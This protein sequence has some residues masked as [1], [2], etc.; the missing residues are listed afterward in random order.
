MAAGR[1]QDSPPFQQLRRAEIRK[2]QG[3]STIVAGIGSFVRKFD[4]FRAFTGL[5]QLSPTKN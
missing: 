3:I 1:S 5:L 4:A 2:I